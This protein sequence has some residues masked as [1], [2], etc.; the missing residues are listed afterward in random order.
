MTKQTILRAAAAA[1]IALA[2]SFGAQAQTLDDVT[3]LP[4]SKKNYV[5]KKGSSSIGIMY[6][7]VSGQR[8]N[9]MFKAGDFVGNAIAAQGASPAQ[10]V[11]LADPMISIRFKHMITD[12]T[13][14]R[15]SLGFSGANFK[16]REYVQDDKEVAD[17]PLLVGEA[18]VEDMI[19]FKLN[20]GGINIGLEFGGGP[21]NLR[22]SGGIGLMYSFGGGNMKFDYGNKMTEENPF[23]STMPMICDTL[24]GSGHYYDIDLGGARPL[25]RYNVGMI[26]AFGLTLDAGVE[27]FF[28]QGL[29]VGATVSLIPLIYAVQ[30]ET[31]TEYEGWSMEDGKKLDFTKK[32][33][34]GS[35]YLLYGTENIGLQLSFNYYF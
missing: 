13:A 35:S 30:P 2:V 21:R 10:M 5:A 9:G 11:I 1:A 32:V 4:K 31:Y 12:V 16:Y 29:S 22:F 23:P 20:G 25:K 17:D 33:S 26:H 18:L 14:F 6:N 3:N 7:P 34:S 19:N 28:S 27:W 8:A 15:A 24:M